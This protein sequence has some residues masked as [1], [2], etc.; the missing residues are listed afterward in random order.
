MQ[1]KDERMGFM[2]VWSFGFGGALTMTLCLAVYY[3][4]GFGDMSLWETVSPVLLYL[5]VTVFCIA[6]FVI[7]FGAF[8]VLTIVAGAF[9]AWTTRLEDR[10]F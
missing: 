6:S 1:V 10:G 5:G 4:L 7:G 2:S 8:C 9:D 3:A